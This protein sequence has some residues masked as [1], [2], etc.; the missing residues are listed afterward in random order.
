MDPIT[1][2]LGLAQFVPTLIR[3]ISGDDTSKAAKVAD[4]VIGVAKAVTG[5]GTGEDA[6][7]AIKADPNLQMQFQQACMAHELSMYQEETKRLELVNET[8]RKEMEN[9]DGYV[10]RARPTHL[11]VLAATVLIEAVTAAIVVLVAPEY[12]GDLATLYSALSVPQ[13]IAA[14]VSGVYV[15]GR[16]DDKQVAITGQHKLG[17]AAAIAQRMGGK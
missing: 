10:R 6:L 14:A 13:G 8:Y 16:S 12:V 5:K 4:Q 11:Y 3:W 2:A 7:A 15:K 17:L 1:I 9:S